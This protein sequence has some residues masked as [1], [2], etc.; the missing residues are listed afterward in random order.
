MADCS[1][2]QNVF[3][4]FQTLEHVFHLI[5]LI[6]FNSYIYAQGAIEKLEQIKENIKK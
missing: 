2:F 5:H 3:V 6:Y 1:N 4:S